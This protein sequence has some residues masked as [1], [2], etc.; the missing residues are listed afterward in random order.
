[1]RYI[2]YF[3]L[4]TYIIYIIYIYISTVFC[5]YLTPPPEADLAGASFWE[6]SQQI[7]EEQCAAPDSWRLGGVSGGTFP[8]SIRLGLGLLT[9]V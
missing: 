6:R 4:Y 8:D 5:I 7:A 2:I 1:M 9:K 3:S